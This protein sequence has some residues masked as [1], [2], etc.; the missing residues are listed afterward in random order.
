MANETKEKDYSFCLMPGI[1]TRHAAG[2]FDVKTRKPKYEI[3]INVPSHVRDQ[4]EIKQ[5][6][7]GTPE[8][9]QW[10]WDIENKSTWPAFVTIRKDGEKI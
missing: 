10:A 5:F 7:L 3:E 1:K 9:C 4:V 8:K 6:L 2:P